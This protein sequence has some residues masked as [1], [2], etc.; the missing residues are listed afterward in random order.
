MKFSIGDLVLLRRTGE[1]GR[2]LSFMKGGL[3]EVEV[4]GISFP[5]YSEE[6]DHPYLNWFTSRKKLASKPLPEPVPEKPAR[7]APRLAQGIYLSFH[8]QFA[9]DDDSRIE[10]FRLFLLNE[11]ASAIRFRYEMRTVEG[12]MEFQLHSTLHEFGN[13]YLHSITLEELNEQPR[14]I[15]DLAPAAES[16]SGREGILRLRPA[17]L[18]KHIEKL[19]AENAP[20][21]SL[22]IAQDAESEFESVVKIAT[23]KTIG[24]VRKTAGRQS[25]YTQPEE[26]VDLHM[27]G[28]GGNV[29]TEQL[30]QLQ[31]KLEAAW[32][33]G[34]PQM[35]VIHGI[36]DGI[37]QKK[38]HELLIE[39]EFVD[40]FTHKWTQ[41]HGMGATKVF[42]KSQSR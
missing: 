9:Q 1:E 20:S 14:F 17:Q 18:S 38:V 35:I 3:V 24:G 10:S 6:L 34:F 21:F 5:V 40:H 19:I 36:G 4:H 37:L 32:A 12:K 22:L 39:S 8:P 41:K 30:S 28:Q 13:I 27:P 7:R 26:I 16:R 33:A 23:P 29:L 2:I 25:L 11:T 31:R 15:W 42:F